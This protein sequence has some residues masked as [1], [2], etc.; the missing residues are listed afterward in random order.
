MAPTGGEEFGISLLEDY[1]QVAH[2]LA[3]PE[4]L[5]EQWQ[6]PEELDRQ[7]VVY[8]VEGARS[9]GYYLCLKHPFRYQLPEGGRRGKSSGRQQKKSECNLCNGACPKRETLAMFSRNYI[10]SSKD[11][12]VIDNL[13]CL[14]A[15]PIHTR[16]KSGILVETI[17]VVLPG[18]YYKVSS[19]IQDTSS[20]LESCC[21]DQSVCLIPEI[22]SFQATS[23][24]S[25][26]FRISNSCVRHTPHS[27]S[28]LP[29]IPIP[30][31]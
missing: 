18:I 12:S 5:E 23:A 19:Y 1:E 21:V 11:S 16:T 6:E 13:H 24:I 7:V 17:P 3:G 9:G 26:T 22:Y 30:S 31:R 2:H 15:P 20:F 4:G 10:S 25:L 14:H 29:P 8:L 28:S 27:P